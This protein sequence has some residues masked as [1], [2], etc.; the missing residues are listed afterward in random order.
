MISIETNTFKIFSAKIKIKKY[1]KLRNNVFLIIIFIWKRSRYMHACNVRVWATKVS[2]YV[3]LL[4]FY[5]ILQVK[6]RINPFQ[7]YFNFRSNLEHVFLVWNP[8]KTIK[9]A[10]ANKNYFRKWK[11]QRQTKLNDFFL[12]GKEDYYFRKQKQMFYCH[13]VFSLFIVLLLILQFCSLSETNR[14]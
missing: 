5:C 12:C 13:C 2:E 14:Q 10:R 6:T 9:L 8:F 7:P 1:N 4:Q 11:L 3:N